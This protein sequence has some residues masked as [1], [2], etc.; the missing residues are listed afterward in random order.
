LI[1]KVVDQSEPPNQGDIGSKKL[2]YGLRSKDSR[3][4]LSSVVN[5][6]LDTRNDLRLGLDALPVTL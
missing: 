4:F 5:A 1:I 6:G 2:H 3:L